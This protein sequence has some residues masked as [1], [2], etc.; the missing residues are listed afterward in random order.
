M[1]A[2]L[3]RT[4]AAK[5]SRKVDPWVAGFDHRLAV[6]KAIRTARSAAATKGHST[7]NK[8]RDRKSVV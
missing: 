1:I 5:R 2:R 3:L 6:R 4:I 8:R 7:Q